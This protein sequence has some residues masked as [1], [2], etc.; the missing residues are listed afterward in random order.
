[1]DETGSGLYPVVDFK[2][3]DIEIS[4][5]LLYLIKYFLSNRSLG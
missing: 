1:M 5:V 4:D 2:A 3:S